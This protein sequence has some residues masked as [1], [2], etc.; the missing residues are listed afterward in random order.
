M[1][2]CCGSPSRR[3][4]DEEL[5]SLQTKHGRKHPKP[6]LTKRRHCRDI[7]WLVLFLAAWVGL[8]AIAAFAVRE[9]EPDRC[10]LREFLTLSI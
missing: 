6:G 2:S 1:G 7:I 5:D 4:A 9:G 8:A 10:V 3:D